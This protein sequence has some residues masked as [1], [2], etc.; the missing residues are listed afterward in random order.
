MKLKKV[1][2]LLSLLLL[3]GGT[4]IF[5]DSAIQSVRVYI[6][7]SEADD[8]GIVVDGKAYLP[9]RQVVGEM[10]ALVGWDNNSKQ[11]TIN[12]PNVHLDRKSVV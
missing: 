10:N 5:A 2:I 7:G 6:N 3:V 11:V 1:A 8:G 4:A 12:K 9:L